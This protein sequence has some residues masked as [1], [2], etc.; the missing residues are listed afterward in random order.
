MKRLPL[1]WPS[2]FY[3]R[4]W[5]RYWCSDIPRHAIWRQPGS[6][7][8]MRLAPGANVFCHHL[9]L[10][11]PPILGTPTSGTLLIVLVSPRSTGISGLG[12]GVATFLAP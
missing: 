4:V 11:T 6:G 7:F 5:P 8:R 2:Y 12:T 9:R 1:H 10:V 3:W